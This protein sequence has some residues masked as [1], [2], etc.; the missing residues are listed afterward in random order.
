MSKSKTIKSGTKSPKNETLKKETKNKLEKKLKKESSE[1]LQ[2]K[3]NPDILMELKDYKEDFID[4]L[5]QFAFYYEKYGTENDKKFRLGKYKKTIELLKNTKT[6]INSSNDIKDLPEI[7]QKTIDKLDELINTS[8]VNELEKLKEKHG[9]EKYEEYKEREKIKETLMQIH[10]IGSAKADQLIDLNIK[11]IEELEERKEEKVPN[12]GKTKK[13]LDLLTSAQLK[14]LEYYH[15]LLERIPRSEIDEYKTLLSKYFVEALNDLDEDIENNNFEIV[16]SYRRGKLDSGDIDIIMTSKKNNKAIYFKFLEKLDK[17]NIIKAFLTKGDI[18]SFAIAKLSDDHIARRLDFLY[19]PP[20]EYAFSILYFTGSKDFNTAM[21]QHALTQNLTLNEH[22]FHKILNKKKG[23][24]VVD[25]K[26]E[27][28][29]DIFDYLNM[30]YKEPNNRIDKTSVILKQKEDQKEDQDQ[31]QEQP[32]LLILKDESK[33]KEKTKS[34]HTKTLKKT[35]KKTILGNINKFKTDGII[36]IQTMSEDELTELL[37]EAINKYYGEKDEPIFTDDEYDVLRNYVLTNYPDNEVAQNEHLEL[38]PDKDKVDL[39]YKMYSMNKIKPSTD[40]LEKFKK[41]YTGPDYVISCKLDGISALYI[42]KTSTSDEKLFTRGNG[43]KGTNITH[44]IPYIIWKNKPTKEL[45]TTEFALR[46]EIIIKKEIFDTKYSKKYA[47]SRNFVAGIVNKKTLDPSILTDIDFVCYEVIKPELKPSEQ[48]KFIENTWISKPV[49]YE[50][51][52][53]SDL[54]NELL[55]EKL[56]LW[57]ETYD[58][59]IDGIVCSE[60][61]IYP[62]Q[63]KN[64]DHAF[65]F[66]MIISNQ[67]VEAR[68]I[69]VL[70]TP[71]KDGLLK[72]RVHIEPVNVGGSLIT[73]ATGFNAKFIVDNKIGLGAKI[74]LIRSGDVIPHI[75]EV[76]APASEPIM[77]KE[78]YIW[79]ATNVDIILKSV[80][81]NETVLVKNITGFFKALE[82]EGLGEANIKKIIKIGNNSTSKI[83]N[84]TKDDFMN[85]ENFKE[86]MA[87][88]VYNSIREKIDK[89]SLAKLASATNIFGRGFGDKRIESILKQHPTILSITEP[90]DEEKIKKVKLVDGIAEKT[91]TQFVKNIPEFQEFLNKA[92]LLN[93]LSTGQVNPSKSDSKSN[94]KSKSDSKSDSKKIPDNPLKDKIIVLSDFKATN[95][96]KKEL[97]DKLEKLGAKIDKGITKSTNILVVGDIKKPKKTNKFEQ[98]EKNEN[99]T[100]MQIDDFLETYKS[101]I[102]T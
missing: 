39:P 19:S 63:D 7:G 14:G 97:T 72:P 62:R 36:A 2:T 101:H 22:G 78:E 5:R 94:S 46:G 49:L 65:A 58:Y 55:S 34:I 29:K 35:S 37:K 69:D 92:N 93:K 13:Q 70:W 90:N 4:I 48:M 1:E 30:E 95:F 98:A 16:G 41:T 43:K 51:I 82:V 100:I 80:E 38:I 10:G 33:T 74:R 53:N 99:T 17:A 96:T 77:P 79:N 71:S 20:E 64:P 23:E 45:T 56:L 21:R 75:E 47:N 28:E 84:M 27:S 31:E 66:K 89:A 44:L 52:N 91:A 32:K 26:F 6:E 40:A 76:L 9:T 25:T 50:N 88:K 87:S 18:K 68:V 60:D 102:T 54:T 85:V 42:S 24:K 15:Q 81:S 11:T 61:N 8:K 73:Y 3:D 67:V 57:R 12:K 59:T 86:K 83:I